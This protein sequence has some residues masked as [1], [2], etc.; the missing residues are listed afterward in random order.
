LT[1]SAWTLDIAAAIEDAVNDVER[2][3]AATK[4]EE[5]GYG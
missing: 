1:V 5:Y 4:A 2:R 3:L